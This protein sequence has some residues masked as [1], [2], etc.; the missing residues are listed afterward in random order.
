MRQIQP[1]YKFYFRQKD[2]DIY[3]YAT[4]SSLSAKPALGWYWWRKLLTP[5][6]IQ[7]LALRLN[8]K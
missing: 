7:G 8:P 2:L 6:P 4:K 1:K 3:A 5:N